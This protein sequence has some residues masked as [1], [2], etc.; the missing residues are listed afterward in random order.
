MCLIFFLIIR[1]LIILAYGVSFVLSLFVLEFKPKQ[2]DTAAQVLWIILRAGRGE[3]HTH[4]SDEQPSA[5]L[6]TDA[7]QV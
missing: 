1:L 4:C 6:C 3:K 7:P 5:T 2:T